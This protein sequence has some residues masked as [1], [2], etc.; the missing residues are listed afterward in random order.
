[1][2]RFCLSI[3]QTL[4]YFDL[5][6]RPLTEEELWRWV[7]SSEPGVRSQEFIDF[8]LQIKK[9]SNLQAPIS[10]QDNFY[11][12]CGREEILQKY[13]QRQPLVEKKTAIARRAV[14][15]I[16][17]V[18][19]IRGIFLCNT[20]AMGSPKEESDVDIFIV[21]QTGRV[22]IARLLS[23]LWLTLFRLRRN[24]KHIRDRVDV[25]FFAADSALDFSKIKLFPDDIYLVYWIAQLIPLYDPFG[26]SAR[27]KKE[28]Q[29]ILTYAPNAFLSFRPTESRPK[30]RGEGVEESFEVTA[31]R[32]TTNDEKATV[33]TPKKFF[34]RAWSGR[35]GDM[36]ESQAKKMQL[37]KMKYNTGS[38]KDEP[39]SRVIVSDTMLKFHEN[40][41]RAMYREKWQEA[42]GRL[43][44]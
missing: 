34:E 8:C 17:W 3:L 12:L 30:G 18:P 1:M 26:I 13:K 44:V 28:N 38:L 5:F 14:K 32:V 40:D 43:G 42:C 41:R 11:C 33:S 35:Y 20:V 24:K 29:W 23:T 21:V 31:L 36:V 7:W 39:D 16:L 6:D 15:K 19:F 9:I 27:I 22:W 4:A 10:N 2:E 37:L 25:S